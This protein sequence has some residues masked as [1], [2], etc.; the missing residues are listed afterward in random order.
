MVLAIDIGNTNIVV[1]GLKGTEITFVAR[2]ATDHA[3]TEDEYSV[4]MKHILE[5]YRVNTAELHGSIISS[6]VP[7]V[8]E[9]IRSAVVKVTGATPLQVKTGIKTGLNI[10]VE[11]PAS[12]GADMIVNAVAGLEEYEAPLVIFDMGTATTIS[13]VDREKNYLGSSICPGVRV[14]L[15]ALSEHAAQLPDIGLALPERLIGRNTVESMRS[16]LLYGHAA[17]V[18]GMIGYIEKELGERATALAT[19]GLARLI[20]P[21]CRRRVVYDENLLLKGLGI[22]YRKNVSDR[23]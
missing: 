20:V 9:A 10:K 18:D 2:M 16:G 8:T 23:R 21:L 6:V 13:V 17:M 12:L 22:L 3:R 1:G 4:L 7:P 14:S 5:L 15:D 19:G 11:N